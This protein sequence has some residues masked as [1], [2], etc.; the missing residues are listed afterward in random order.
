MINLTSQSNLKVH[1]YYSHNPNLQRKDHF[2]LQKGKDYILTYF[3]S[4]RIKYILT[5][6]TRTTNVTCVT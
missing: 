1:K 4:S 6:F 2:Q 5:L 3:R